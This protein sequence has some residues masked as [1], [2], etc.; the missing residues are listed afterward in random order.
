[1]VLRV[2]LS[3]WAA[4]APLAAVPPAVVNIGLVWPAASTNGDFGDNLEVMAA[5]VAIEQVNVDSTLLPEVRLQ[6]QNHSLMMSM[7]R[8]LATDADYAYLKSHV[9]KQLVENLLAEGSVAAVGAGW[10]S[11][12]LALSPHL[13]AAGIPLISPSATASQLSNLTR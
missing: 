2:L 3:V 13:T 8:S 9:A 1:M 4:A 11:D 7:I 12:V 5:L 10:S 6:A